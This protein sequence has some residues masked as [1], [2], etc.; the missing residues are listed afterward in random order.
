MDTQT[1]LAAIRA[2]VPDAEIS[3]E[4]EG[5]Q[6]TAVVASPGFEGLSQVRRQQQVLA[7]LQPWLETG[8]L[9]AVTLRTY[10]PGELEEVRSAGAA[11]LVTL[12]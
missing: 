8:E 5:C 6:F 3:L 9:H 2:A 12:A 1:V 4:G 7:G 10:T 11:G